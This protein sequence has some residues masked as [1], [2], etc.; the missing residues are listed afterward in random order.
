MPKL[1]DNV[2]WCALWKFDDRYWPAESTLSRTRRG[3]RRKSAEGFLRNER[4]VDKA[5]RKG[6][7][8]FARVELRECPKRTAKQA[9]KK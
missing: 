2:F 7:L 5:V 6:R 1:V 8:R 4:E 3:A 9:R